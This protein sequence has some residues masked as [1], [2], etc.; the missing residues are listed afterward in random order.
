MPYM[1]LIQDNFI[2]YSQILVFIKFKFDKSAYLKV[3]LEL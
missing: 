3:E 1:I 2:I